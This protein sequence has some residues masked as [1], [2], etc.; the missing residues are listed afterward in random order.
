MKKKEH[1]NVIKLLIELG[2]NIEARDINGTTP[3]DIALAREDIEIVKLLEN[4]VKEKHQFSLKY[5]SKK[6]TRQSS[7][8]YQESRKKIQESRKIR[9]SKKA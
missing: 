4:A 6:Q 1:L 2:A 5:Q 3:L 7:Q 8:K 9:E